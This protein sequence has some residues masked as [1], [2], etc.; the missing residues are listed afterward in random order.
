MSIPILVKLRQITTPQ[1]EL[2]A[3]K[4]IPHYQ[5][6]TSDPDDAMAVLSAQWAEHLVE[7]E[8]I[9]RASRSHQSDVELEKH[10]IRC[11]LERASAEMKLYSSLVSN[12]KAKSS[13]DSPKRNSPGQ[14]SLQ[15]FV[16]IIKAF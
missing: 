12:T 11:R 10:L 6:V 16:P 7:Q 3:L 13:E 9:L 4:L 15:S 1:P 8:V 2:A 5:A 14:H